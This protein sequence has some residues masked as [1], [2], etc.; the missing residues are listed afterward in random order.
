MEILLPGEFNSGKYQKVFKPI[1]KKAGKIRELLIYLEDLKALH[2]PDPI[3]KEYRSFL[4]KDHK[5]ARKKFRKVVKRFDMRTVNKSK[6]EI[7]KALRG[8]NNEKIM[9]A[10]TVFIENKVLTLKRYS[11]PSISIENLHNIRRELKSF[12]TIGTFFYTMFPDK[13]LKLALARVTKINAA[14]GHIHDEKLLATSLGE[15]NA[16]LMQK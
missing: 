13:D 1:F 10:L 6:H 4:G 5:R 9:K 15:F 16:W 2:L 7:N 14:I 11:K 8:I 3:L 12:H